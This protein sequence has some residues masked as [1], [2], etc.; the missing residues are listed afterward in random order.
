[1][2]Q[3]IMSGRVGDGDDSVTSLLFLGHNARA[4]SNPIIFQFRVAEVIC[5]GIRQAMRKGGAVQCGRG[6]ALHV[7]PV[8]R[9][10]AIR[11]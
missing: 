11:H 10:R 1:M 2:K 9:D 3:L 6:L 4:K 7:N 8:S 5:A